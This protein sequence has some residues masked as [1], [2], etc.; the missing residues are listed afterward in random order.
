MA[1]TKTEEERQ[2]VMERQL[3]RLFGGKK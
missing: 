3:S 1:A 2:G